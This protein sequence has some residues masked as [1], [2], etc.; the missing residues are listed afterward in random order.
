MNKRTVQCNHCLRDIPKGRGLFC[1]PY[2]YF[3]YA[4]ASGGKY[5]CP[6]CTDIL[7]AFGQ[8][9]PTLSTTLTR[10]HNLTPLE[11]TGPA[12]QQIIA[13]IYSAGLATLAVARTILDAWRTNLPANLPQSASELRQQTEARIYQTLTPSILTNPQ[14]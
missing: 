8:L 2:A 6:T 9:Y 4:Q 7:S 3:S 5:T 13:T 11:Y 14:E 12:W 10:I 1:H